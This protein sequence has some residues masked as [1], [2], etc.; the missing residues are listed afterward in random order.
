[1]LSYR[2]NP[3]QGSYRFAVRTGS[4]GLHRLCVVTGN[5]GW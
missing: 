2:A 4:Q 5:L 3:K 1:M